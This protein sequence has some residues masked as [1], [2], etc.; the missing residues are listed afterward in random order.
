M[1]T[2]D[3]FTRVLRQQFRTYGL[4]PYVERISVRPFGASRFWRIPIG[5]TE[6]PTM[7]RT[8]AKK[9]TGC[10]YI[11]HG[12][13]G[14][15][16]M[17]FDRPDTIYPQDS[18]GVSWG[19][20]DVELPEDDLT[21]PQAIILNA[22]IVAVHEAMEVTAA[23]EM[24]RRWAPEYTEPCHAINK[25]RQEEAIERW[26]ASIDKHPLWPHNRLLNSDIVALLDCAW[27]P[28]GLD[29]RVSI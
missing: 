20:Y 9:L 11:G 16:D 25:V 26:W 2:R 21:M 7:T 3:R 10:I 28:K 23:R 1:N 22:I 8:Q 15:S 18:G 29:L 14:C 4:A 13:D 5:G 27:L 12:F 19:L 24:R 6:T 17:I